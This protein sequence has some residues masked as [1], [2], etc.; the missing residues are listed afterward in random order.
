MQGTK[1][2]GVIAGLALAAS[3]GVQ[4]APVPGAEKNWAQ[5]RGPL[6][7][8]A[9]PTANPPTTWSEASNV[10][11]KIKLP[12]SGTSTPIIWENRLFVATAAPVGELKTQ[13]RAGGGGPRTIQPTTP[14]RFMLVCLDRATGKTLWEKVARE[15]VPHEGH[16]PDHGYAS[17][18]PITDGKTVYA[19][20]GSRGLYA[21]DLN[22]NLKWQKEDRKSVV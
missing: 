8:G 17:H 5:W 19:Y 15:E 21:Y 16:H 20:F 11:W 6:G 9:S 18:S 22:G 4:G 13:E 10:R 14:M 7:T 2:A 3:V 12:G 1:R